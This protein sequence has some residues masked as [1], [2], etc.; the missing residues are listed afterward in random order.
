MKCEN[1]NEDGVNVENEIKTLTW[2]E[3]VTDE[4]NSLIVYLIQNPLNSL[5]QWMVQLLRT[6]PRH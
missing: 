2:F 4:E 6:L 1:V 5:L 3:N